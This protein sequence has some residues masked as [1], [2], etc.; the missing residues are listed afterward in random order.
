MHDTIDVVIADDHPALREGIRSIISKERDIDVVGAASDGPG[1]IEMAVTLRP[2]VL[3]L[4]LVMAEFAFVKEIRRLGQQEPD[5]RIIAYTGHDAP[6]YVIGAWSAGVRGYILKGEDPANTVAALR[7]VAKG[8]I[9]VSAAIPSDDILRM[10]PPTE[11]EIETLRCLAQGMTRPEIAAEV[12][13]SSRTVRSDLTSVRTKLGVSTNA[14][15]VAKAKDMG[16][17]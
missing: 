1:A 12:H 4:D 5:M 13:V 2:D 10:V 17:I 8:G 6:A 9:W 3:L 15:A 11:R 16:W 14:A 7:H